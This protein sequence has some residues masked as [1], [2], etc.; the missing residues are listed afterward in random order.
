MAEIFLEPG[1]RTPFV[2]AGGVFAKHNA[3]ELS[4]PIAAAM[5][6]RA[7]P[8]V[9]IWSQVIPDPLV[10]NIAR[11]LVFEADLN[12]EIPAFSI[13]FACASSFVGAASAAGMIGYGGLHLALVGGVETMS[14]AP[15][16]LRQ[17]KA[18]ALAAQFIR[19]PAGAAAVLA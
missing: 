10:S 4:A 2:K 6:A 13:I 17:G 19:D 9:V 7:T 14:H 15:I 12:P 16:A 8:D 18:D 3:L 5:A 11:E 1:L